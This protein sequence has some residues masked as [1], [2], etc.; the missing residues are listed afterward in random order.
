MHEP[1][2]VMHGGP[3][4][5][6]VPAHDFSTNANAC[7]PCP[8]VLAALQD[9]DPA[10]YPDPAY[11]ALRARLAD[12][13]R[14][15]VERVL[16]AGSA[17]EFMFRISALAARRR[18]DHERPARVWM[19]AHGYADYARAARAFGMSVA[20]DTTDAAL[21]WMCDPSSPL[22]QPQ[23]DLG[24]RA[25]GLRSCQMCVLDCAY[26]PLRLDGQLALAGSQ[27][28]RMW[29]LCSPNKALGL[30]GVRGAY[31]IA[32][33]GAQP[34]VEA[35]TALAPSW[36]IGA[37]GVAMLTAWTEPA[38]AHWLAQSLHILREWR[39]RQRERCID[40]GWHVSPGVANFFCARPNTADL[41]E[42]LRRLRK[43]GIKLRDT[44]SFGLDGQVRLGVLPPA[45]QDALVA[46]WRTIQ[47]AV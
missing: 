34:L 36:L 37:H 38:V 43:L 29:Q 10:H 27:R 20:S 16:I 19:P 42:D 33:V 47:G 40:L 18:A 46:G 22:G 35:L 25:D 44:A 11:T 32:P 8:S 7:G 6:G 4:A 2:A 28:E 26:E 23:A 15:P 12:R 31:A 24:E 41:C 1:A 13:H 14:V 17:S 39:A 45:S 9:I 3:D 5:L 21:L 30:T